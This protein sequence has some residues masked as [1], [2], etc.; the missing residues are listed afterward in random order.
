MKS[1][2]ME[3]LIADTPTSEELWVHIINL[4][5]RI[6]TLEGK[7]EAYLEVI[8]RLVKKVEALEQRKSGCRCGPAA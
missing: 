7:S 6:A 3:D 5:S 2:I 8:Q 4:T 1:Q